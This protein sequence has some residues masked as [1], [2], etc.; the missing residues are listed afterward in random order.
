[1]LKYQL[2]GIPIIIWGFQLLYVAVALV[3]LAILVA[4]VNKHASTQAP[5]RII[6]IVYVVVMVIINVIWRLAIKKR[7]Q[8]WF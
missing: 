3:V 6:A 8:G 2:L 5:A 1:M 4:I 7:L